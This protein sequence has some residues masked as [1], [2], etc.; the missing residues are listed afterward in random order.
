YALKAYDRFARI[1]QTADG[2]WRVSNPRVA[3]Q[4]RM[5]VGAI[6][7]AA[8]IR[9]RLMGSRRRAGGRAGYGG[10][11]LGEVEEYFAQTMTPGDTFIFAGETLR[12][13][14][15]VED[16]ALAT[17]AGPRADP[18]IPSYDGGKFPLSTFLAARVRAML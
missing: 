4:Y 16:E 18:K 3:Q 1:R 11:I 5:N 8:M 12:F 17:R 7:E 13:E 6:V 15:I 10:R 2:R 14:G 9:V